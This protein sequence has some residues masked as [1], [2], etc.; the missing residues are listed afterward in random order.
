MSQVT[1]LPLTARTVP[2]AFLLAMD[3]SSS[4]SRSPD[5]AGDCNCEPPRIYPM[6]RDRAT[7]ALRKFVLRPA[8]NL[9]ISPTGKPPTDS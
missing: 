3:R 7:P 5:P 6:R 1:I 2:R 9:S 8:D 4:K